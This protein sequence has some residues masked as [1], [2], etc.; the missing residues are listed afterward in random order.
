VEKARE[1]AQIIAYKSDELMQTLEQIRD[2]FGEDHALLVS[3]MTIPWNISANLILNEYQI[4]SAGEL[5]R[6]GR[7]GR[8][9]KVDIYYARRLKRGD[10]LVIPKMAFSWVVNEKIR[11]PKITMIEEGTEDAK[12]IKGKNPDMDL[13]LKALVY[14]REEGVMVYKDGISPPVFYKSDHKAAEPADEDAL[15]Q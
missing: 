12:Q 5:P 8:L 4:T 3:P 11:T 6:A 1:I 9:G 15:E 7:S 2:S 13:G 14:A 10:L